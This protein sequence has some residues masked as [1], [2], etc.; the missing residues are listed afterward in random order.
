M[1]WMTQVPFPINH[2]HYNSIKNT[3]RENV[4]CGDNVFSKKFLHFLK[5][6]SFYGYY[7]QF[8]GWW[9][10]LSGLNMIGCFNCPITGFQLQLSDYNTTLI[11]SEK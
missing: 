11:I 9:I 1:N 3:I 7:D 4:S 5:F 6:P 2:N 8:C 10:W